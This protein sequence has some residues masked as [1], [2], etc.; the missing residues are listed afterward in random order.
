MRFYVPEWDDAVDSGYDFEHDELSSLHRQERQLDYIWDIFDRETTPIDGVLIS[1]EQV[2]ETK[3]K[4]ERLREHGVY[5]DSVLSI[6]DWL[7]TI[8]DCGAWGY[9][10]FPFPP[11][12][13]AEMLDFYEDLE[14]SVGV[15]IDHLVLGSGKDKGRL[16]L[17]ERAFHDDFKKSHVPDELTDSVEVMSDEWERWP[18]YVADYDDSLWTV[19]DRQLELAI[20]DKEI[21]LHP[22][23]TTQTVV[24]PD[25]RKTIRFSGKRPVDLDVSAD[26]EVEVRKQGEEPIPVVSDSTTTVEI[27]PDKP[28]DLVGVAEEETTV[29]VEPDFDSRVTVSPENEVAVTVDGDQPAELRFQPE[30]ETSVSIEAEEE[31]HVEQSSGESV[32]LGASTAT[33]ISIDSETTLTVQSFEETAIRLS[34]E[35]PVAVQTDAE[36]IVRPFD[37]DLFDGDVDA[38]L[39]RLANDSRVVYRRDDEQFR[40]DLTLQNARE[41]RSLYEEGEYPFRLM[42]AVQGWSPDSYVEATKEV[43]DLGYDYVGIGG[44]AGSPVHEVRKIV[45]E[46]GKTITAFEREHTTRIDT[47]VFGFAKSDAFET[48]GR[49]GM[50][51]FDSASMLRAAW[52]G[53]ENYR[54]S[55]TD[56]FDAI[57]VRYPK[58]G[59]SLSEAV[60]RTL[61]GRELLEALR[62]YD[63]DKSIATALREW[64]SRAQ[65]VLPA[66]AEYLQEHRHDPQFDASR[67]RDIT[68]A[69][70]ADFE[71]GRQLRAYFSEDLRDKLVKLLRED[72]AEDPLPFEQYLDLLD[73]A[74]QAFDGFPRMASLLE[75]EE[76]KDGGLDRYGQIWFVLQDYA[77]W[78]GDEDL[79]EA[80]QKTLSVKPWEYCDCP[81]CE[82]HGIEVC[83]FRGND[84][85]RRRGFHNTRK[86]YDEFSEDL[87]KTM[88]ATRGSV[89]LKDYDSVEEYLADE[90][91]EFWESVHDLPVA[92]IGVID[93]NGVQEWSADP[94]SSVSFAPTQLQESLAEDLTRYQRLY[95]Y[96]PEEQFRDDTLDGVQ[97]CE[98]E[99]ITESEELRD[100]VLEGLGDNY[101]VGEDFLPHSPNIP[102]DDDLDILVIDQCSGSKYVPDG[103]DVFEQDELDAH[104]KEELLSR[105]NTRGIAARDLYTGRQ[106]NSVGDAVRRLRKNGHD[107]ERY[108]ISAGFGL[109]PE[110]E[111]LPPYEVTF[112]GMS[113]GEIRE[114]SRRL[115][116]KHD[117]EHLLDNTDYDV[118]F[119]ALGKDYY[120]SIDID[121]MVQKVRA[122]R[123]GVVFNRELVDSQ[124]ENIVSV[125][126]RTDDAKRHDTIVIGLKGLYLEHFAE[127]LSEVGTLTPERISELCRDTT[128]ESVQAGIENF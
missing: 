56:R 15:T 114:R 53:G 100:S 25:E 78:I 58:N 118:V 33:S 43:L 95:L 23:T 22:N 96:D 67:L 108:F 31:L 120:T 36:P 74:K 99:Q 111:K 115:N 12:G 8:S 2:E 45:K 60:E 73:T 71:H 127:N 69:F 123:I 26:A 85:N 121:Q 55:T 93:A 41:M 50:T 63:E 34:T 94:P 6:P 97:D 57:R 1:R 90:E 128:E 105:T 124:F 75:R 98:I 14:V 117:V 20:D 76:E 77:F 48:I 24:A 9:K 112:S 91:P 125:P 81:I 28:V 110:S 38:T 89:S 68:S 102:V 11:Y 40:Y 70:R 51:S 109:V 64:E 18:A 119:F 92:E 83:I 106:Q 87:P 29:H 21:T 3:R 13:N 80:Y 59:N 79:L 103:T 101:A 10:S 86:F 65:T 30:S 5:E 66:T 104:S 7:P 27:A 52:T 122:D 49:S 47:H 82:E 113:V 17:D 39:D 35:S 116:I 42:V 107:V 19:V 88:I 72:S 32:S 54:L 126:A 16:Y 61:R 44:V 46:V 37:P 84:R 62:A 4:R